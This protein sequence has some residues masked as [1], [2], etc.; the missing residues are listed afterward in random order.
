MFSIILLN[1]NSFIGRF[2][3]LF[4][5]LPIGILVLAILLEWFTRKKNN[6]SWNQLIIYIWFLGALSALAT[7]VSGWMLAGEGSYQEDTLFWHRWLGVSLAVISFMAWWM[8]RS[9][10][11]Y[12]YLL[13]YLTLFLLIFGGHLGGNLTH[14]SNYL[15]EYAPPFVQRL[16]GETNEEVKSTLQYDNPDS[17]LMY[18]DLI[19][20]ILEKKCISCHNQ[21]TQRGGL[22][23]SNI[24]SLKKGGDNGQVLMSGN[25]FDSELF[26]RV[27]LAQNNSKFM[28]P[29]GEPLTY[30]EIKILEWWLNEGASF[31]HVVSEASIS[32]DIAQVLLTQYGLDTKAKPYYE[33]LTV[34]ALSPEILNR[35]SSEGY[36]VSPLSQDNHLL[37]VS[38]SKSDTLNQEKMKVL[39]EAKKH[40]TWLDLGKTGL[41]DEMLEVVGQFANLSRLRLE[42]NA[43]SD[44][45]IEH[46]KKLSH[47]E[48]LNLYGNSISDEALPSLKELKTLKHIYLWQTGLSEEAIDELIQ[49]NSQLTVDTGFQFKV[50]QLEE[51]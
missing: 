36:I 51:D 33:T 28:P 49:A 39:L 32:P 7:V 23:L 43:I 38:F 14:G 13:N 44:A 1:I 41:T 47:L 3:P 19:Q 20:P 17:T 35:L 6:E 45:G 31:E 30:K 21:E 50:A 5:H 40:I 9:K 8:K 16:L 12:H 18:V 26:K 29:K 42:N 22:N 25:A 48:S 37:Q 24:D 11:T 10:Q 46:L 4:V 34:D 15:V 2:H 27:T